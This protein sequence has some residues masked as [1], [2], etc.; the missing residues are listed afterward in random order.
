VG[1]A[2]LGEVCRG[3]TEHPALLQADC[4]WFGVRHCRRGASQS[5]FTLAA[6]PAEATKGNCLGQLPR[7]LPPL[8]Q[9]QLILIVL[10]CNSLGNPGGLQRSLLLPLL[11]RASGAQWVSHLDPVVSHDILSDRAQVHIIECLLC[12]VNGVT[13]DSSQSCSPAWHCPHLSCWLCGVFFAT[14]R[15]S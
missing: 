8:V 5:V 6:V 3:L 2:A 15:G 11:D 4:S 7:F 10:Q 12:A 14:H 9:E 13:H 1:R